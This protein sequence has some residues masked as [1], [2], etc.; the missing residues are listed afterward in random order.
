MWNAEKFGAVS[1]RVQQ[2]TLR[3][4]IFPQPVALLEGSSATRA[5]RRH[6]A[7][8][9]NLFVGAQHA[10][11]GTNAWLTSDN[12]HC[13]VFVA[14]HPTPIFEKGADV[15][16]A[17]PPS[18][19]SS[20]DFDDGL[21]EFLPGT[22]LQVEFD[23]TCSKQTAGQFLPGTRIGRECSSTRP[24]F[25]PESVHGTRVTAHGSRL[26]PATAFRYNAGCPNFSC[27]ACS[28]T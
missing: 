5:M 15:D 22:A 7:S 26:L 12:W 28:L 1:S 17:V 16:T 14:A 23:V 2:A 11:P 9:T 8:P 19:P 13:S 21:S 20:R 27:E 4:S 6:R 25:A 10:A 24:N 3:P 18:L